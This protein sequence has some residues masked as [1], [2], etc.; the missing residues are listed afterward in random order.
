[1]DE[2]ANP[3]LRI[4]L[5]IAAFLMNRGEDDRS[6]KFRSATFS[7]TTRSRRRCTC[8]IRMSVRASR[9]RSST[10]TKIR[11]SDVVDARSARQVAEAL[12]VSRDGMDGREA[13]LAVADTLEALYA[14]IGVPTRLRQ[15]DIPH[16]DLPV[17]AHDTVK[18]FNA[19]RGV[20]SPETQIEDALRLL[21]AAYE[22]T[23]PTP[24][25][26]HPV[27]ARSAATKQP[28]A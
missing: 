10:R 13:A 23:P 9:P 11:L 8:G 21:D 17:V 4:D 2:P 27:I 7:A 15:L 28:P 24:C 5:C 6:P 19:N 1:M 25:H 14:R 16:E 3:S 18:N 26:P 22:R 20:R 12:A